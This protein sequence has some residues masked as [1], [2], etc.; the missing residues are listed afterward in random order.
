MNKPVQTAWYKQ[1]WPWFLITIPLVSIILSATMLKLALT[2][3]NSLVIDD[4]YK[5]GKGINLQ[6]DR[7]EKAKAKNIS[8]EL[9]SSGN[10]IS[11]TFLSGKPSSGEALKLYFN[12]ATL[13]SKD[14]N[15]LL[16]QD[17]NGI[18]RTQLSQPLAGKWY[19]TLT[20][21]NEEWK[22]SQP[23][24]FPRSNAILLEP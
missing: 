18:Y 23:L 20:P 24:S 21:L 10:S 19:V 9:L 12:H 7:I 5:E 17:A 4:Y 14:F 13:A 2:T 6:L 16:S 3:E 15:I 1:F 11:I 8:T 22:V